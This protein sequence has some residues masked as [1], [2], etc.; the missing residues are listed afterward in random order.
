M[1]AEEKKAAHLVSAYELTIVSFLSDSM[2]RKNA[3]DCALICVDEII[4]DWEASSVFEVDRV[5]FWNEVKN[6]I[7]KL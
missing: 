5:K 7:E 3:K 6:E 2:K 1:K 4:K